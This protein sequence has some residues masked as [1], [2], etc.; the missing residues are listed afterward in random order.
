MCT[1]YTKPKPVNNIINHYITLKMKK[2]LQIAM[3]LLLFG[4]CIKVN[5]QQ[6]KPAFK[7]SELSYGMYASQ[8]IEKEKMDESPSGDH[9]VV[10]K[11]VLLKKTERVLA[12]IGSEFGTEY[13]LVGDSKDTVTLQLEWIFPHEMT[14]PVKKVSFKS[15][16]YPIDLPVNAANA[17]T[18]SLDNDFEVVKGAWQLNIYYKDKIIYSK[19]FELY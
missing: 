5:A 16:K 14:D 18:Y 13:K 15:I 6:T 17:S 10:A 1:N 9:K 3:L 2:S 7:F 4:V 19:K 12:K 8:T 11:Q